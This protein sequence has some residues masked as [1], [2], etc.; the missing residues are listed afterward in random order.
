MI[1][2]LYLCTTMIRFITYSLLFF[3]AVCLFSACA[4]P[5]YGCP[6]NPTGNYKYRG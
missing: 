5:K 4:A 3:A 1:L 2:E 6:S